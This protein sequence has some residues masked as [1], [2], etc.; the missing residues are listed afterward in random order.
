MMNYNNNNQNNNNINEIFFVGGFLS[1]DIRPFA[2]GAE[3]L[4]NPGDGAEDRCQALSPATM[5][6]PKTV[7]T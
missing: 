2:N 1:L 7:K 3:T 5:T 6:L 4:S